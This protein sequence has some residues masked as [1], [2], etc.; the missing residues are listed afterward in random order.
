MAVLWEYKTRGILTRTI[1]GIVGLDDG[2]A[3]FLYAFA[4]SVSARLLGNGQSGLVGSLI[5]PVWEISGGIG[6]GLLAGLLLIFVLKY[7][8]DSKKPIV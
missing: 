8:H 3:L 1:L 6:V 7:C 2:L 4:G 5:L